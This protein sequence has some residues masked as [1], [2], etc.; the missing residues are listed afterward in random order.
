M[1]N[2]E[3]AQL[4]H[5]AFLVPSVAEAATVTT[6]FGFESGLQETWESEGTREIYVGHSSKNG[7][8]L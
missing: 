6:N 3:I 5:I 8:L 1:P 2:N 4:N 7:R